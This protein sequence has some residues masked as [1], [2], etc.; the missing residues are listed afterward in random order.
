MPV[1]AGEHRG[2]PL[3]SKLFHL[4]CCVHLLSKALSFSSVLNQ[5]CFG[6]FRVIGVLV[7]YQS[8][9]NVLSTE[10]FPFSCFC[11]LCWLMV[12]CCFTSTETVGLLGTGAQ[13]GHLDFHT[14]PE[15]WPCAVFVN[16]LRLL[17]PVIT[18]RCFVD[19]PRQTS[20]GDWDDGLP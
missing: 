16:Q 17:L 19:K 3:S 15:L 8:C 9:V 10:A 5:G 14:A 13:D 18:C 1:S 2:F 7:N 12:E 4:F 6:C 20:V 11:H